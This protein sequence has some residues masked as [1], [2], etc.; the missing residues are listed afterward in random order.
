MSLAALK[1]INIQKTVASIPFMFIAVIYLIY[2]D[3][4]QWNVGDNVY[5]YTFV[6]MVIIFMFIGAL[7]PNNLEPIAFLFDIVIAIASII[8][9]TWLL[10]DIHHNQDREITFYHWLAFAM[11]IADSIINQF[12]NYRRM[13]TK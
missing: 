8:L 5:G 4:A 12:K 2:A 1:K 9:I 6:S 7:V 10:M 3:T 13:Y 11:V